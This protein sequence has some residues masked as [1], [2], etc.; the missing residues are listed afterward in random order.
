MNSLSKSPEILYIWDKNSL[1]WYSLPRMLRLQIN[2]TRHAPCEKPKIPWNGPSIFHACSIA[3]IVSS[4]PY[5]G[6][7]LFVP[8]NV[9]SSLLNHQL[10]ESSSISTA[11]G[12]VSL[13]SMRCITVPSFDAPPFVAWTMCGA[14]KNTNSAYFS[15][16]LRNPPTNQS[17][18]KYF[19]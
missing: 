18:N 10:L 17:T 4:K 1:F 9:R 3:R 14:D 19:H 16:F 15:K 2:P 8:L 12:D 6:P 7:F 13:S 5:A 11:S